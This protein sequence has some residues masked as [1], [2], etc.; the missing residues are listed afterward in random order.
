MCV[1]NALVEQRSRAKADSERISHLLGGKGL[2]PVI[3]NAKSK[4]YCTLLG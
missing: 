2:D 1:G 4:A 3:P